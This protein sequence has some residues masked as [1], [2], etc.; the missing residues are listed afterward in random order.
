MIQGWRFSV[1]GGDSLIEEMMARAGAIPSSPRQSELIVFSGGTD[2]APTLYG[3]AGYH[4][5]TQ[6]S[7]HERDRR[8]VAMYRLAVSKGK[9]LVGICRGA[10][11]LNV[12][13][14]GKLWQNVD[15]HR[16]KPHPVTYINEK[17]E[18][19]VLPVTSDHH[20]MM[21]MGQSGRL[22][23]YAGQST[24]KSSF[25]DDIPMASHHV[26][27]PEIV[28]YPAT[29]SLCFQPHPEWGLEQCERLFFD[30]VKRMAAGRY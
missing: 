17:S 8:E 9:K 21:I 16:S 4:M 19:F 5:C 26:D 12:L 23:G 24:I 3:E 25:E 11:L 22:W 29:K 14:G 6:R 27:D 13:N 18:K 2:V 7:D 28:Y 30:C 10:Q 20:Q 15:G 1:V